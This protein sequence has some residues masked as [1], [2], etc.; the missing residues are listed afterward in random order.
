MSAVSPAVS[1]PRLYLLRALYLLI[2]VG[3]GVN[4]APALFE[5]ADPSERLQ[6]VIN[7]MLIAFAS[8]CA[9]GVRYP[10]QLLPVLLWELIWKC[11]WLLTVALPL[12]RTGQ[13]DDATRATMGEIAMVV[14]I[15]PVLPW[16]YLWERYVRHPGDRWRRV[17]SKLAGGQTT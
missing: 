1:L 10:L 12:W 13:L 4:V 3:L 5:P 8:L 11:L 6:S 14:I 7:C 16:G 17:T 9:L 15:P 2:A